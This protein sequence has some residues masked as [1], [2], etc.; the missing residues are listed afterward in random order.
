MLRIEVSESYIQ[1]GVSHLCRVGFLSFIGVLRRQL[2]D[3][4][5]SFYYFGQERFEGFQA[6][7][8]AFY[9]LLLNFF[10]AVFSEAVE[11]SNQGKVGG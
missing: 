3:L 8:D 2:I 11:F 9:C 7:L 10:N 1:S 4:L 5:P 6:L